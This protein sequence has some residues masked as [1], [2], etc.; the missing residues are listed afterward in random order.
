[1]KNEIILKDFMTADTFGCD[2]I[3]FD[4][5]I[6]KEKL[7]VIFESESLV[8]VNDS[9]GEQWT[10]FNSDFFVVNQLGLFDNY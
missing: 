9:N 2:K 6:K 10:V 4:R 8:L 1:M 3:Y 7:I 5:F